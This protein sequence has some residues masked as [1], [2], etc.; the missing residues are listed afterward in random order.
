MVLRILDTSKGISTIDKLGFIGPKANIIKKSVNKSFGMVLVTGPTGSG[1]STTLYTLLNMVNEEEINIVTLEDPVEYFMDGIN[2]SQVRSDIGYTF[3]SGLRSI[4]RQDPDIIMVGEIRDGETASLAVQSALTGHL[5]FS[6][7]HT[8]DAPG[9][10][11]R[12]IDMGVESF[13]LGSSLELIVAQRL[14]R[15]LCEK[16]KKQVTI[17][18]G[19]QEYIKQ[20][21]SNLESTYINK[22]YKGDFNT[23]YEPVGCS[24]C[25]NGFKGRTVIFEIVHVSEELQYIIEKNQGEDKIREHLA[26]N[27]F[28]SLKQD[29]IFKVLNGRTS[30][31]ELLN[32]VDI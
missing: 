26:K 5:V 6:T 28:V 17:D 31:Q 24:S 32:T 22:Y 15:T 29:G 7:L 3:A 12:L 13:L 23:F 4:L 19:V 27:N 30:L 2:Q 20:S 11:P 8:N 25:K 16:C 9:A 18:S 1:K 10:I 21:L 14:V